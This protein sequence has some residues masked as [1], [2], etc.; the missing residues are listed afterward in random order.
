MSEESRII[1]G[2]AL[3]RAQSEHLAER[4]ENHTRGGDFLLG[5]TIV[6]VAL[7]SADRGTLTGFEIKLDNGTT[8]ALRPSMRVYGMEMNVSVGG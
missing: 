1:H 6:S 2:D 8:I 4:I 3:E 5:R 7:D